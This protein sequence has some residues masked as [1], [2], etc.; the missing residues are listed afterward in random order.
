MFKHCRVIK[1][2]K[3]LKKNR[4]LIGK[5]LTEA[6]DEAVRLLLHTQFP[7]P[8]CFVCGKKIDWYHPKTNPHGCQVGHY[9]SRRI[10][11][12]RWDMLNVWPQC[13]AC[14][15]NHQYNTLPF[16]SRILKEYGEIRISY[17]NDLYKKY[18]KE[19]MNSNQKRSLLGNLKKDIDFY[20]SK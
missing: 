16:T 19:K 6:L 17:L 9:I 20:Q 15:Y 11:I 18:K 10:Y 7:H 13:S 14:N 8:T 2:T 12:L 1:R 5:K 3:K 4:P